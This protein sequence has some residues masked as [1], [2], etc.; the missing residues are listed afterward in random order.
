MKSTV[1][2]PAQRD[3]ILWIVILWIAVD[4]V[5]IKLESFPEIVLTAQ[6]AFPRPDRVA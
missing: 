1:A 5:N 4:V 2:F 6:Y 3:Q